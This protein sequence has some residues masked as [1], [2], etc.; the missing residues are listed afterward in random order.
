MTENTILERLIDAVAGGT[1]IEAALLM[2]GYVR[3]PPKTQ[4]NAPDYAP[5]RYAPPA[6]AQRKQ[7][8]ATTLSKFA[9]GDSV[10]FPYAGATYHG[11][12]N[13]VNQTTAT[14]TITDIIGT[15]RNRIRAGMQ[16]R[17]G[18]GILARGASQ[19]SN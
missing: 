9:A 4:E 6:S 7:R 18:A 19:L 12:V 10:T 13:K 15:T 3:I 14:V 2:E 5:A 17:V 16:V 8:N 1:N 11:T